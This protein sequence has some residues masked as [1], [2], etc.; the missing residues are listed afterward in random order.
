MTAIYR[1]F[2]SRLNIVSF[3]L[4]GFITGIRWSVMYLLSNHL[5]LHFIIYYLSLRVHNASGQEQ[6][7][8]DTSVDEWRGYFRKEHSL[9]KPYQGYYNYAYLF[10]YCVRECFHTKYFLN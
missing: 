3:F 10:T 1:S 4:F 8:S 2:F 5:F 9:A 7:I 6:Q